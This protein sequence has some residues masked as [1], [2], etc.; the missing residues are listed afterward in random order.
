MEK[1]DIPE[2]ADPPSDERG[3]SIISH[4]IPAYADPLQ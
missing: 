2:Q 4:D 1:L 3:I